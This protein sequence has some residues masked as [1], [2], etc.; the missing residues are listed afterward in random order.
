MDADDT[1]LS[2]IRRVLPDASEAQRRS[3]LAQFGMTAA[4]VETTVGN[5]SGGER[6][7][8][9][10]NL[11]AMQRPHLLIL[12]EPTNHLDIDSR[13]VLAEALND[14][15]GAVLLI[16]HDRSMMETV[17]DRLWLTGGGTIQPFDGDMDDYARH[18]TSGPRGQEKAARKAPAPAPARAASPAP[19]TAPLRRKLEAA[20][21]TLSRQ[22]HVAGEL[23]AQLADPT[24]HRDPQKFAEIQQRHARALE[25]LA[26]AEAA[27]MAAAEALEKVEKAA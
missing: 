23:E 7:R 3:R 26:E 20:E 15:E 14:Y 22:N 9:L 1:P 8:L 10:L 4:K 12:D 27:W 11:V 6:A 5:L 16:A 25:K 17:V 13:A 18:V 21:A 2:I 19:A 24:V